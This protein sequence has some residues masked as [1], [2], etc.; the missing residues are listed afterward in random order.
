MRSKL[1]E[2]RRE[3]VEISK[4]EIRDRDWSNKLKGKAY[5]DNR[6]AATPKSIRIGDAVLLRAE[7][8]TSCQVTLTKSFQSR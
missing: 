3:T 5:A 6:R 8:S 2:L 4:E 7:K 1:P